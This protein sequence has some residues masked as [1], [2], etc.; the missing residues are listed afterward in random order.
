MTVLSA[1]Q[2][3]AAAYLGGF[4]GEEIVQAVAVAY[5]ESSW[6]T[7]AKNS[8]CH[9]LW[10][11]NIQAHP[12]MKAN[13]YDPVQNAKYAYSIYKAAGGWCTSGSPSRHTCN[14]WQAYGNANYKAALPKA[15][16]AKAYLDQQIA[17]AGGSTQA[18]IMG[19]GVEDII[20]KILQVSSPI[21]AFTGSVNPLSN[22]AALIEAINR[23][24]AWITNPENLL[25]VFKVIMGGVVITVGTAMLLDKQL[26]R[27]AE[28]I[29]AGKI[30]KAATATKAVK[31][32]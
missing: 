16:A 17:A 24:G 32:K 5:G 15:Q 21:S 11:I 6:D 18:G 20:R 26:S 4:R 30:A 3:A 14:P 9:G 7:T 22:I 28:V 12:T 10:Q 29:P 8:C 2:V 13:V 25:R 27:V 23:A 19:G 1:N 31:G